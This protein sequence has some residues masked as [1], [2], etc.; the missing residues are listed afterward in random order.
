M[1]L[2]VK[3]V[4]DEVTV[5]EPGW[6]P[7]LQIGLSDRIQGDGTLGK[8]L[9]VRMSSCLAGDFDAAEAQARAYVEAFALARR[10]L[11]PNAEAKGPARSDGPA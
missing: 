8:E 11:A 6:S 5:G 10:V 2:E 1:T 9:V 4:G 3:Q 7:L